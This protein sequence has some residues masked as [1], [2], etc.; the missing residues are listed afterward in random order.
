MCIYRDNELI[1]SVLYIHNY[2]TVV[3][4]ILKY[5]R[6]MFICISMTHTCD[7]RSKL[8][9]SD[10]ATGLERTRQSTRDPWRPRSHPI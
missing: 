5:S 3:L 2:I 1:K 7:R 4:H 9:A 8:A 6:I 10:Q